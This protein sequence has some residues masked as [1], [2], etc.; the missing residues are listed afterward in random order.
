M[1]NA[2]QMELDG[3]HESS[4][5]GT[6]AAALILFV[7]AIA[8]VVV[9]RYQL[10]PRAVLLKGLQWLGASPAWHA[11]VD[12]WTPVELAL[13]AAP[14]LAVGGLLLRRAS[15]ATRTVGALLCLGPSTLLAVECLRATVAGTLNWNANTM[16]WAGLLVA[17][18]LATTTLA[19]SLG[20]AHPG[21]DTTSQ[22]PD[23]V[24]ATAALVTAAAIC[25]VGAAAVRTDALPSTH[26]LRAERAVVEDL[27]AR[28]ELARQRVTA[29]ASRLVAAQTQAR[30][31][32]EQLHLMQA[33]VVQS[34]SAL[35]D[36]TDR[37]E[38]QRAAKRR[39]GRIKRRAARRQRL[40]LSRV[41]EVD[42][43]P[44]AGLDL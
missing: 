8:L 12:A 22:D 15:W 10:N 34:E 39:A 38:T 6:R 44:L 42:R 19:L 4:L 26:D 43:D 33:R 17:A 9:D 23:S 18:S 29:L 21:S 41:A 24:S 25:A 7:T 1:A 13:T 36:A 11:V 40:S 2:A 5:T 16:L 20:R 32:S 28:H 30:S 35:R 3:S 37:L 27:R 31:E 14:A